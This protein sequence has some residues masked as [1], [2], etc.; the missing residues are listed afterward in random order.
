MRSGFQISENAKFCEL[1]EKKLTRDLQYGARNIGK[2][3]SHMAAQMI[4][5]VV[6]SHTADRI[7]DCKIVC[8]IFRNCNSIIIQY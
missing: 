5:S 2:H 3:G 1:R 7:V 4:Q 8:N 6:N